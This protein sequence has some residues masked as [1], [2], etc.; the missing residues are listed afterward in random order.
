[1][2]LSMCIKNK[3]INFVPLNHKS[4]SSFP[5]FI[6]VSVANS[7]SFLTCLW[8]LRTIHH[9]IRLSAG[10]DQDIITY[11]CAYIPILTRS[12]PLVKV[13]GK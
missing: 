11:I 7:A 13:Y 1:M 5:P 4:F 10:Y 12:Y 8:E 6:R 9:I 3:L 2:K